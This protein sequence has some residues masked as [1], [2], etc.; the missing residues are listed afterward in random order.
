[1]DQ[2]LNLN[3]ASDN[4]GP[5]A[6][7]IMQ[8]M[9][10]AN[11]GAAMPYGAD[12]W[13]DDVR[14][15]LRALFH[16]PEAEVL[17]VATGTGANALALA[18]MVQPWQTIFAHR[19][20]HIEEDECGAPEFYTGGA[21]LTLVEGQDGKMTP[22][23]LAAAMAPVGKKGVHGVQ[24]GALSLTNVTEAGT[25]YSLAELDALTTLAHEAGLPCHLDG[26]RFAN[27]CA[28]LECSA[29]DMVRGFNMVSF[30][31]T[32]NGCMAVEAVVLRDP[33][34]GWELELRRKRAAQLWSKHRYLSVQMRAYLEDDLWLRNAAA[35]NRAGQRLASGLR[36]IGAD[37]VWTPQANMIFARLDRAAHAR[38]QAE[39]QYYILDDA[40]RPLCRLV[41]DFTKTDAEVDRLLEMVAG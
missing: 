35:A 21:K 11:T 28:A 36:N 7:P 29:A 32:K 41:C 3:F 40:E 20:S 5:V 19:I 37:L 26:A 31:G 9:V 18:G 2:P 16:W 27:A 25:L 33:A 34:R 14:D 12:P 24:R 15:R 10:E 38:A 13:M 17:L 39:A 6:A 1:M 22:D 4:T 8:A 30:G 23:T